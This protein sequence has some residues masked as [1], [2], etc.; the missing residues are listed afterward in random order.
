MT[1]KGFLSQVIFYIFC[2]DVGFL[3]EIKHIVFKIKG[4]CDNQ[5]GFVS[6]K[7]VKKIKGFGKQLKQIVVTIKGF[8]SQVISRSPPTGNC[9]GAPLRAR[10]PPTLLLLLLEEEKTLQKSVLCKKVTIFHYRRVVASTKLCQSHSKGGNYQCNFTLH[11][12]YPRIFAF[13]KFVYLN[14]GLKQYS[15]RNIF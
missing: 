9:A 12:K 5:S 4:C 3:E 6:I 10:E 13:F 11:T 14:P 15:R 7:K 1:I 2:H 8:S